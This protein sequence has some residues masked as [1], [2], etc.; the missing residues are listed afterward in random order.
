MRNK[1]KGS[2][3]QT[4]QISFVWLWEYTSTAAADDENNHLNTC[5]RHTTSSFAS[6]FKQLNIHQ[7]TLIKKART[8]I[9]TGGDD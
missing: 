7:C 1:P 9:N 6:N 8:H 4:A 5:T 2:Q 3:E